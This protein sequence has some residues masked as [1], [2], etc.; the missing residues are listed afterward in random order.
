M[1]QNQKEAQA[2]RD[3]GFPG[4]DKNLNSKC[5]RPE[6]YGICR[7]KEAQEALD[8][9]SPQKPH[10]NPR[11]DERKR[12]VRIQARVNKTQ[13]ALLQ[14]ALK[15]SSHKTMD[16]FVGTATVRYAESILGKTNAASDADTSKAATKLNTT[17]IVAD[18]RRIVNADL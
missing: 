15:A 7:V 18:K 5:K 16:E 14:R 9:L 8:A 2:I 3:A 11:R 6:Y 4:Y 10:R 12:P 13:G 17:A 1:T